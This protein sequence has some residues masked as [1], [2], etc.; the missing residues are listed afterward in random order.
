MPTLRARFLRRPDAISRAATAI[1]VA[2]LAAVVLAAAFFAVHLRFQAA[3]AT[4]QRAQG[5][6][7]AMAAHAWQALGTADFVAQT[8]QQEV[9]DAGLVGAN[10]FVQRFGSPAES[11]LL[12]SRAAVYS[13]ST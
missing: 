8:I 9:S 11:R 13:P 3:Q 6:V 1:E 7:I 12:Q 10:D 4:R 2:L 5:Q